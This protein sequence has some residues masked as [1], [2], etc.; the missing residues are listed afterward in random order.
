M[1]TGSMVKF[2]EVTTRSKL[3][4]P[5][6]VGTIYCI[7]DESRMIIN[8]GNI[9]VE[10]AGTADAVVDSLAGGETQQA[11]SVS[12]V[13]KALDGKADLLNGK[14]LQSQMPPSITLY[15][16]VFASGPALSAA[17]PTDVTGAF[18][19]VTATASMWYW[20]GTAWTDTGALGASAVQSVNNLV[21]P[22]VVLTPADLEAY[23]TTEVDTLLDEKEDIAN[24]NVANGYAPLDGGIKVPVANLP[25]ASDTVS[26]VVELA[27]LAE[28][29]ALSDTT[30]AVTPGTIPAASETQKGVVELATPAETQT[31]TDTGRGVTPA[32]LHAKTFDASK[33][34]SGTIA[35][36]RLPTATETTPGL[37]KL[38][39]TAAAQ[40]GTNATDA[41][42]PVTLTLLLKDA[43]RAA[44]EAASG[45]KVTVLY[46]DLGNPSYMRRFAP[47][48]I[49]NLYRQYYA[50]DAAWNAS[51]FKEI[52]NQ[53]HPAFLKGG[54]VVK[55]L[56]VG[57]YLSCNL[58][59]RACSLPGMPPVHLRYDSA[60]SLAKNKGSGWTLSTMYIWGF[61]QAW[62][63]R[64]KYQ[65][66]GNTYFGQ[67]SAVWETGLRVNGGISGVDSGYAHTKAG[68]GP[69]SWNHDGTET[70]VADLVG[71]VAEY[72]TL[73]KL[74]DGKIML[75]EDNDI[76]LAESAWPDSGVRFDATEGTTDGSGLE[77]IDILGE[78]VISDVITKYSG[79]SGENTPDQR[80]AG[81]SNSAGFRSM[82]KKSG[83]NVPVAMVLA[84]LAPIT[85]LDGNYEIGTELLGRVMV[86]NYGTRFPLM[87]GWNYGPFAGL[88]ALDL[89]TLRTYLY[90]SR[91]G[92]RLA[93]LLT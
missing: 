28:T 10:Y 71:N 7:M 33:I 15:R 93:Y 1:S 81:I 16:G 89:S 60:L 56:M 12:T 59:N 41:I 53:V 54:V 40:T 88:G 11:P 63:L 6:V 76:D 73:M 69:A 55:E 46:D 66:R 38:A 83:Y 9:T 32:G 13:A 39:T 85:H 8:H 34:A 4:S 24:K 65:P 90:E 17:F 21:G 26:G 3:P 43:R 23:G 67:S 75:P 57:K 52:E 44:V 78:P 72:Q 22:D 20:D 87:S 18:A 92:S 64:N 82:T 80:V 62:C 68:T 77:G 27:T 50:S 35:T 74:V 45:G 47:I 49:K 29:A 51:P 25:T 19:T 2:I 86:R 31:G 30:R 91:I 61:L 42:T 14:I 58:N 5:L 37:V 84:G 48:L 36:D 79:L 70:G